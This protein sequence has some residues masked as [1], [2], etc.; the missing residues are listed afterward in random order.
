[1]RWSVAP[2][3]AATAS[4]LP[5]VCADLGASGGRLLTLFGADERKQAGDF[6]LYAAFH[7]PGADTVAVR[8]SIPPGEPSYP[9]ITPA[10][11][12]VH[13]DERE[14]RDLLGLEPEGHP[15]PRPLVR[16]PDWPAGVYPLRKDFDPAS[17]PPASRTLETFEPRPVEGEGV[18]EVPVGPIHAG[19]IE[20]GHFR[21]STVGEL[22]L[23][24][25]A[26]LFYAHRGI[27]KLAEGRTPEQALPLA[28]RLCGACAFSHA[29]AYCEAIEQL[30]DAE[31]PPRARW[32]RTVLLELERLY[33]HLGD[34]GNICA[35]TG[36]AIGTMHGALLK[37]R[38]Q[39]LI[40]RLVGNRF[41][42]GAC[43]LGGL[44]RDLPANELVA[45]SKEL[46]HLH[47][48]ARAF[49]HLLVE[50][51]GFMDRVRGTG[52]LDT[53]TV[54]ALGGVG[55]A[56]RASGIET[57]LR[58]ERPYASYGELAELLHVPVHTSGDVEA[59]L[60]Q[61]LAEATVSFRLL[62]ALLNSPPAG[63]IQAAIGPPVAR[64]LGLGAVESPRGAN[65]HAVLC[66]P[67]GRI[68]RYRVRSASFP[69][70]PL[71]ALAAPGN[72]LPDFPLIN[73]S[74]E[75][76]YACLDR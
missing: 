30:A 35:G 51:D 6:A 65:V 68:A 46:E 63:P 61:R 49:T 11:P 66:D 56:A 48:E 64:R 15:D 54:R 53:E 12:A 23:D 1:M 43:A 55:V 22:V 34:A 75:L 2:P 18:I 50:H 17:L 20:P 13:W 29:V 31:V 60:R 38:I 16:R 74:F 57:D 44:R 73:K 9:S 37:E 69:N 3:L 28:E 40:E 19:I 72:L 25:E 45:A 47:A 76:C 26:R 58:R 10:L 52:R 4:S 70:W 5:S 71:V 21:F 33:N 7:R 42:R 8:A 24:L 27:E 59:R 36:F 14:Q 39:Q 41:L 32:G 62:E 67:D